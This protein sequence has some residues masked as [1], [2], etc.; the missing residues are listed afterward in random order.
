MIGVD[1]RVPPWMAATP[2]QRHDVRIGQID[3]DVGRRT[4]LRCTNV[5]G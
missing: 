1:M 4:G 2:V 3:L 5:D